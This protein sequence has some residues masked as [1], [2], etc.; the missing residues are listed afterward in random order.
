MAPTWDQATVRDTTQL[1]R[2]AAVPHTAQL[3]G[4]TEAGLLIRAIAGVPTAAR[5]GIVDHTRLR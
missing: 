5:A 1:L 3:R 4:A 2:G